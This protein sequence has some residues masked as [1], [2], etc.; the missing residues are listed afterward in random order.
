MAVSAGIF[1]RI[2]ERI[3][4]LSIFRRIIIGNA[5]IIVF[6]AVTGTLITRYL[7]IR[8]ADI[9]LI[10]AFALGGITLSVLINSLIVRTALKPMSELRHRVD[11]VTNNRGEILSGEFAHSD[12]DLYQLA[13]AVENL[14]TQ[15]N[16][17]NH[18]L[19]ALSEQVIN[20]QEDER[21]RIARS[22][23]DDTGQS[24][25]TLII[26]LERLEGKIHPQ[27]KEY[28][29]R[30]TDARQLA[31][32]SL[33]GLRKIIHGLRPSILDD[34]G[35]VPAIRWYAR[36]QL[37]EAGIQVDVQTPEKQLPISTRASTALFRITQEA[38]NNILRHSQASQAV[39]RLTNHQDEVTLR[40]E[41]NGR[42]FHPDDQNPD[43]FAGQKWGL[44]GIRERAELIGGVMRIVSTSGTGACLEI[45]VPKNSMNNNNPDE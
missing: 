1:P 27:E 37:E 21:K 29:S 28:K 5:L 4:R 36:S 43:E 22:L 18:Q 44:I 26:N 33:T 40:I 8:A 6:G 9:S 11:A 16:H 35:L 42:G 13:I 17:H 7:A 30:L 34:L 41:D 20:A 32:R 2:K 12:P 38:V 19:R 23:H 3:L 14:I 25:T 31:S 15:C 24:L 10:L 45:R 39:I